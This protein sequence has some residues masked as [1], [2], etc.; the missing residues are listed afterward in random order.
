MIL[1]S[2][3]DNTIYFEHDPA[4]TAANIAAIDK[5]CKS[6]HQFVLAT[7]RN[8]ASALRTGGKELM[9]K[10]DY[11][12]L[13]GGSLVYD[14]GLNLLKA[15]YLEPR[16]ISE[17]VEAASQMTERP[18]PVYY[19]PDGDTLERRDD[20]VT[21]LRLRFRNTEALARA[22]GEFKGMPV[23][24]FQVK[25]A[26]ITNRQDLLGYDCF[27]EI[28]PRESGKAQAVA[29]VAERLGCDLSEIITIGDDMNDT[30]M[31]E[32]FDGYAPSG[33]FLARNGIVTKTV[34]SVADLVRQMEEK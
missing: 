7:G 4:K 21:K 10:C 26:P 16:V 15:V 11:F 28:L 27:L 18:V 9:E 23:T 6:G 24:L 22:Y 34:R 32:E 33:S 3:F 20:G 31:L 12:I 2:D 19:T 1:F 25:D 5:W 29:Y 17:I 8:Y 30:D 13:D 14:R